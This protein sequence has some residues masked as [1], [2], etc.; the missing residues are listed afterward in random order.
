MMY[1]LTELAG[2][3]RR[4]LLTKTSSVCFIADGLRYLE[5]DV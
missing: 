3:I 1:A 5:N 4:E 2:F